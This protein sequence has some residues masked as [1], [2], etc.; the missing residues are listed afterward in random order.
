[1]SSLVDKYMA[2]LTEVMRLEARDADP[3]ELRVAQLAL[4]IIEGDMEEEHE[5][6]S[7][8]RHHRN[9]VPRN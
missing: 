5:Q 2:A 3:R 6:K 1:M 7:R 4:E 9:R 8:G